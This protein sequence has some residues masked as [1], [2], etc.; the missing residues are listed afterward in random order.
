[1]MNVNEFNPASLNSLA[2]SVHCAE[3]YI[4]FYF[5]IF[6]SNILYLIIVY[7]I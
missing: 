6:Y 3:Y 7:F 5:I 1:M 2:S 4:I